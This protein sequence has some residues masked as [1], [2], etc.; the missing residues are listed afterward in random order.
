MRL[1]GRITPSPGAL[2]GRT[3]RRISDLK[4]KKGLKEE[5]QMLDAGPVHQRILCRNPKCR[6]RLPQP[7]EQARQAF[8][9]SGCFAVYFWARCLTCERPLP[10]SDR[11]QHKRFCST[12]CKSA[13]HRAPARFDP[14]LEGPARVGAGAI[15]ST[16]SSTHF[17]GLKPALNGDR[18]SIKSRLFADPAAWPI[19][20]I[21]SAG[22][23]H[24]ARL[25]PELRRRIIAT[26]L[27]AIRRTDT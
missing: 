21:G 17:T 13:F 9:C 8:C 25:D 27:P 26:E 2:P 6:E 15:R 22:G 14:F 11:Q 10:K 24:Q 5:V 1:A 16:P 7:T 20:L 12:R 23:P 4:E 3:W 18:A 19:D